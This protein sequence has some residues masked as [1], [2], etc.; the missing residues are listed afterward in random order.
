MPTDR[1]YQYTTPEGLIGIVTT[2]TLWATSVFYLNDSRELIGGIE[3][4]HN[5]LR[6]IKDG[7]FSQQQTDRVEWL[8]N[9]IRD[10]GKAFHTKPTFVASLTTQ[11]DQLSQWRAY[12]RGGGFAIGF[13]AD[14]LRECVQSQHCD[15]HQCIYQND[16]QRELMTL[17][18]ESIARH[19]I[20][21]SQ[22]PV[23]EDNDRFKISG[24]LAWELLRTASRIKDDSF[25]EERESRIITQPERPYHADALHFRSRNGLVVPYINI[26]LPDDISFW[27]KVHVVVGPTPHPTE[28]QA[29]VYDLVRRYRGNAIGIEISRTPYREG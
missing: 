10:F 17:T 28:S 9:D 5:Y 20:E 14:Q 27:G 15:L 12:C 11:K 13:P 22:L 18:V 26:Q 21:N 19:W 2:N 1:L 23:N 16:Q 24:Q 25:A 8:L 29:S 7:S 3:I 4:A 6:N